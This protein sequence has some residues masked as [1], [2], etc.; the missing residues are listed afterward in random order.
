M[1]LKNEKLID[2]LHQ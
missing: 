2:I 1:D